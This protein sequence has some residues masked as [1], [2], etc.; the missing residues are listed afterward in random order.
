[1]CRYNYQSTAGGMKSE[2]A[3]HVFSQSVSKYNVPYVEFLGDGDSK[4]WKT[5]M[6]G[7]KLENLSVL[8]ITR[9]GLATIYAN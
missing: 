4:R 9:R 8:V 7:L 2:G 3:K 1:M 6:M 5:P